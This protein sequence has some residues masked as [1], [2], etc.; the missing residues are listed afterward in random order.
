MQHGRALQHLLV[1]EGPAEP[2]RLVVA[3]AA[4]VREEGLARGQP[5]QHVR[6]EH[7]R[8]AGLRK[9]H[10]GP[11]ALVVEPVAHEVAEAVRLQPPRNHLVRPP[12]QAR[13]LL[14]VVK[15]GAVHLRAI[16]V[17]PPAAK[18]RETDAKAERKNDGVEEDD[19]AQDGAA[20]PRGQRRRAVGARR[21]LGDARRRVGALRQAEPRELEPRHVRIPA[22]GAR[23]QQQECE[24][25]E[26][27]AQQLEG[28][29]DGALR[30]GLVAGVRIADVEHRAVKVGQEGLH[31][32]DETKRNEVANLGEDDVVD[33]LILVGSVGEEEVQQ[34]GPVADLAP[35]D[36]VGAQPGGDR[37][38]RLVRVRGEDRVPQPRPQRRERCWTVAP[39]RPDRRMLCLPVPQP[40]RTEEGSLLVQQLHGSGE[41]PIELVPH[42]RPHQRPLLLHNPMDGSGRVRVLHRSQQKGAHEIDE[43]TALLVHKLVVHSRRRIAAR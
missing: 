12:L 21:D 39:R 1:G 4:R 35:A 3:G 10:V 29:G 43:P 27:D 41:I 13:P 23:A 30:R 16:H 22:G 15:D 2:S 7:Q 34:R 36:E 38:V 19:A 6:E 5:E 32:R 18:V 14:P 31:A 33:E 17:A 9:V 8:V 40:E 28:S 20:P 24:R 25:R 11:E 37:H 42:A 26:G